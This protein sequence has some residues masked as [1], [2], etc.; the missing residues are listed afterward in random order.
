MVAVAL[1]LI[2]ATSVRLNLSAYTGGTTSLEV[3]LGTRPDWKWCVCPTFA[4]AGTPATY[5]VTGLNQRSTIYGRVRE[6]G[7]A[8]GWVTFA[9][10]TSDGAAQ[11]TTPA[12]IMIEPA[13]VMLP[14]PVL[15]WAA[16]N[17]QAGY[18][19]ANLG[20]DAPVGW[21]GIGA[22]LTMTIE[23]GGS[24]WD[25]IALLNSNLPEGATVTIRGGDTAV[26]AAAAA[27]I[28]NAVTFR[29]SVNMP[30]RDGYHGWFRLP[31]V[32]NHR[33]AH[34]TLGG[35]MPPANTVYIEHALVGLARQSRNHAIEKKESGLDLGTLDRSRSGNPARQRGLKMRTVDFDIALATES[36]Y[37]TLY[38]DIF[39]R[40]GETEPVFVVP[41]SKPG[42]FLHDRAL[43]GNMTGGST[44]NPI[45]PYYTRT[46]TMAS[47]I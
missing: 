18:P 2:T 16:S 10:R 11:V 29:A 7:G 24:P 15:S 13:I 44:T 39:R 31:A 35:T 42:P 28:L 33:F 30:G 36:Q 25:L 14:E 1:S 12:A 47:L 32:V 43:Y 27:P 9:F 20:R 4:I 45:A 26:A 8:A 37:E 19:V 41:N 34:I 22:A 21:K 38:A 5:D 6:I 40:A 3:Q 46:F 17:V 23:M